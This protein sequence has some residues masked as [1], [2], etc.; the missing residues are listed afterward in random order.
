MAEEYL[1]LVKEYPCATSII[2]GHVFKMLHHVLSL[3]ENFDVRYEIAKAQELKQ[4]E[5]SVNKIRQ[6]YEQ[7]HTGQ[8]KYTKASGEFSLILGLISFSKSFDVDLPYDVWLC[9][10]YVRMP[11][12]EYL[13]KL[14]DVNEANKNGVIAFVLVLSAVAHD[15]FYF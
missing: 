13:K 10:P 12:D 2:R 9:Q 6:R 8:E 14:R 4:F 5:V 15:S 1:E 3:E 7:Y 11:P